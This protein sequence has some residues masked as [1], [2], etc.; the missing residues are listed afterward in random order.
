M[1]RLKDIAERASVSVM[2]VSK[3]LR[4]EPD[5]SLATKARLKLLA[6][7]MGYVPD[8]TAQ[9]LRTRT[10]KL[11]GLVLSSMTDPIFARMVL[12]IEERAHELGYDLLFVHT[13]NSV[14]REEAGI[15]RLLSRRVDGIFLSPVYR[16]DP[17]ARIY[18]ELKVRGT[19]TVLLGPP[20][21]F[22]SQF[23]SV[24]VDDLL[25]SYAATQHLLKLGHKRIAFLCGPLAAPWSQE[26]FEGYRRALREA[27][28]DVDDRLIFQAGST[29]EDGAKAAGQILS[30]SCNAT[31]VQAVNDLVAV[32]C[33]N[34]L[35]N[36]G[37]RIPES[38]S[39]IGFGNI[40]TS[41][42]FRIPLTTVRQ[43]KFRLGVA[44]VETMVQLL[45]SQPAESKRLP[46]DLVVR[47]ST[48]PPRA[49]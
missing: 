32:G 31:A 18:H 22:C 49:K 27:G 3:A 19:P 35:L 2:T 5:V 44:A 13:L 47:A 12:A 14:E 43:P 21:N 38:L 42:Y 24:Q 36:Q 10:T 7:Q 26:R 37:V 20:A 39:I 11:F 8:S 16:I 30:E 34:A 4:D 28:M 9:G 25:A 15:R 29:V 17:E 33:A 45:H 48:A 41:E 1:V 46:A 23:V 40:L 6:Q